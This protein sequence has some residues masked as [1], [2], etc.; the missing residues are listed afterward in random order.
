M[1]AAQAAEARKIEHYEDAR[2]QSLL[3][4]PLAF[5]TYG[6]LGRMGQQRFRQLAARRADMLVREAD[7]STHTAD[8][9]SSYWGQRISIRLQREIADGFL[10]AAAAGFAVDVLS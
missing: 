8:S 5:E 7:T 10:Y 4:I 6:A 3:V 9:F 2:S 1:V